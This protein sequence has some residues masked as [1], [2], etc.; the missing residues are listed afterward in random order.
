MQANAALTTTATTETW[1][2]NLFTTSWRVLQQIFIEPF[3]NY[4][5][6]V[7]RNKINVELTKLH[8]EFFGKKSNDDT[9]NNMDLQTPMEPQQMQDYI[10]SKITAKT[11]DLTLEITKLRKTISSLSKNSRDQ[12]AGART[13]KNAKD[14]NG[15][16]T[17]AKDRDSTKKNS[18]SGPKPNQQRSTKSSTNNSGPT[19]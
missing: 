15:K 5:T 18:P 2:L 12:P 8:E 3:N 13:K 4:L 6:I 7:K 14:A 16:P 10:D 17:G 9:I 1:L 19:T 11:K